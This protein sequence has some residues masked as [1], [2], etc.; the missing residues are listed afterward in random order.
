MWAL[1]NRSNFR[2]LLLTLGLALVSART[3]AGTPTIEIT[4]IPPFGS[5]QELGGRVLNA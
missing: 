4:N 1:M 3:A 5:L 2:D